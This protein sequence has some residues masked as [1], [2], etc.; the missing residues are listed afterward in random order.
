[1]YE[2]LKELTRKNEKINKES[3]A[4]FIEGLGISDELKTKLKEI[5]PFNYTGVSDIQ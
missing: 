5:S 4:A 2:A 3:L 1:M